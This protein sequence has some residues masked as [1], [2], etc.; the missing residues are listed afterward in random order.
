MMFREFFYMHKSDRRV[1]LALLTVGVVA[2]AVIYL[3]GGK[4]EAPVPPVWGDSIATDIPSSPSTP[5]AP[6]RP[7][8]PSAPSHPHLTTALERFHFDPNTADST[9]L[10]RLG[11]RPW[12]VRNIYKYRAA[13]G[14]F[15]KRED[16]ARLYGLTAEQY[17]ELEPYIR[18]APSPFTQRASSPH[19]ASSIL[20]PKGK[21]GLAAPSS[22]VSVPVGS[23]DRGSSP[24]PAKLAPGETISLATADTAALQRIPGIG[25]YFARRIVDYGQ[26]LGGYVSL[27]QLNEIEDFPQEALSYLTLNPTE[28]RRLNI[29]ALSLNELKRHPYINFYQARAITDYRRQHG[30]I[31]DLSDLRLL[32]DFPP[33]AIERLRPYVSY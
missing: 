19:P 26:R 20:P 27:S 31:T 18:I 9:A 14:V 6:S 2:L 13:G 22:A 12:Q 10:L 3:A 15:R 24:R 1:I 32:P 4:E 21:A 30:P 29:N 17:R 16:F 25:P 33:E 28:V 8:T 23:T 5:F 7:S 11:L